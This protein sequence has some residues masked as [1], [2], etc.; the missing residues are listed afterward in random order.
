MPYA[1]QLPLPLPATAYS[2]SVYRETVGSKKSAWDVLE[3]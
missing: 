1:A 3:V 2:P